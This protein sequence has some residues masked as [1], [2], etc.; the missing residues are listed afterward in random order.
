[1]DEKIKREYKDYLEMLG[2]RCTLEDY[3]NELQKIEGICSKLEKINLGH[4]QIGEHLKGIKECSGKIE[5]LFRAK[6]KSLEND[7]LKYEEEHPEEMSGC[8]SE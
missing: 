1:L 8:L 2:E 6:I 3:S 4:E 7:A 5:L